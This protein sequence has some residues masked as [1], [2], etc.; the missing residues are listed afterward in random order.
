LIA[1]NKAAYILPDI[2]AP[3]MNIYIELFAQT[4]SMG[5]FG[6]DGAV[7]DSSLYLTVAN[8]AD[9]GKIQFSPVYVSWNGRLITAQLFI[10]PNLKP[11]AWQWSQGINIPIRLMQNG[12]AV[13]TFDFYVVKPCPL[14]DIRSNSER[15]L[16]DG[17]LGMRSPRGAMIVDSLILADGATYT[18]SKQDP[19]GDA[20]NGNQAYLPFTLIALGNITG[21][22]T[23]ISV[24]A[25]DQDGGIG[26]GGGGGAFCDA[27]YEA[28]S[29]MNVGNERLRGGNG[30]T[31]GGI[32]GLHFTG[33]LSSDGA[34]SNK[35]GGIGS[36][37]TDKSSPQ[38]GNAGSSLNGVKGATKRGYESAGGGTGHPFGHSGEGSWADQRDGSYGGGSGEGQDQRGG[39][40]MYADEASQNYRGNG[41]PHGNS[42]IVPLAGGSGGASGNPQHSLQ[43]PS[44]RGGGGGGAI[45]I[46]A[47][48]ITLKAITAN[49][50]N[51]ELGEHVSPSDNCKGGFGSGG[52]IILNSKNN[53]TIDTICAYNGAKDLGQE[54]FGCSGFARTSGK[55]ITKTQM[56][57][58]RINTC[59]MMDTVNIAYRTDDFTIT[60]TTSEAV[61]D[62]YLFF[63]TESGEWQILDTIKGDWAYTF[64]VTFWEQMV[65][66]ICFLYVAKENPTPSSDQYK[67][68]PQYVLSQGAGKIIHLL[69][70][71]PWIELVKSYAID[72]IVACGDTTLNVK[73]QDVWNRG[74]SPLIFGESKYSSSL[75]AQ[76]FELNVKINDTTLEPGDT[77]SIWLA[78][79]IPSSAKTGTYKDTIQ[80][81]HN[82]SLRPNPWIIYVT[83]DLERLAL[84]VHP[85]TLSLGTIYQTAPEQSTNIYVVNNNAIPISFSSITA[86]STQ[87]TYSFNPTSGTVPPNDSI[88]VQ[89]RYTPIA[90]SD[91]GEVSD[92]INVQ[93]DC[94]ITDCFV[95]AY[96]TESPVETQEFPTYLGRF[97]ICMDTIQVQQWGNYVNN[98]TLTFYDMKFFGPDTSIFKCAL[99]KS[100]PFTLYPSDVLTLEISVNTNGV[101]YG[102]K[103]VYLV[104]YGRDQRGAITAFQY[105]ITM[106]VV[107]PFV[108]N[109]TPLYLDTVTIDESGSD[110]TLELTYQ[111]TV[112]GKVSEAFFKNENSMFSV[113]GD[114]VDKTYNY[115]GQ[116]Q[117]VT[118]RYDATMVGDHWDTLVI[119]YA[120]EHCNDT[121]N[122]PVF[123]NVKP[124][125]D[126]QPVI[127]NSI[128][129]RCTEFDNIYDIV[130]EP[131]G[132]DYTVSAA[133]ITHL[134][135]Y[136]TEHIVSIDYEDIPPFTVKDGQKTTIS[137]RLTTDKETSFGLHKIKAE[138]SVV[139]SRGVTKVY[140]FEIDVRVDEALSHTP[141]IN[142]GTV[143]ATDSTAATAT[144]TNLSAPNL[145]IVA[146]KLLNGTNFEVSDNFD[147]MLMYDSIVEATIRV[148]TDTFGLLTDTLMV[149]VQY[150]LCIDTLLIPISADV[151]EKASANIT[152]IAPEMVV[153]PRLNYVLPLKLVADDSLELHSV[154][155]DSLVIAYDNS[156][157]LTQS[158]TIGEMNKDVFGVREVIVL[159]NIRLAPETT[160]IRWL[161]PGD[162]I[163][164]TELAG[165]ALLGEYDSTEFTVLSCKM[166]SLSTTMGIGTIT[167]DNGYLKTIICE[168]G[169]NRLLDVAQQDINAEIVNPVVDVLEVEL[170]PLELGDYTLQVVDIIGREVLK[171]DFNV[172]SRNP[173]QLHLPINNISSGTYI[174][175]IASKSQRFSTRVVK[176]N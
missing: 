17:T 95:S 77:T 118:I 6:T 41:K 136:E 130:L 23:T 1:Q 112:A 74:E 165:A 52:A 64:P 5:A 87:L 75:A 143:S 98:D 60:G 89:V 99:G 142:Y 133:S 71:K 46:T 120:S 96:L 152:I 141:S 171:Y 174:V 162:T 11:N 169:G 16:G 92:R 114:L 79:N 22:G 115:F 170:T 65:D 81:Q 147:N 36:G 159:T 97:P 13:N 121:M 163:T 59:D 68:I 110:K 166:S 146:S 73:I 105:T 137:V 7:S 140:Q 82:D 139:E 164:F 156:M 107:Q 42:F 123:I 101:G 122:V 39:N 28:T 19:D 10:H 116:K 53:Y 119:V 29:P 148:A 66:S 56:P 20:S 113:G 69:D 4:D 8:A 157:F 88:L 158:A 61:G 45:S 153:D 80:I 32:G 90:N 131:I 26:G 48:N 62:S 168:E 67:A 128:M 55:A 138:L 49:G 78:Y 83:F 150:P 93:T 76:G 85:Q 86:T 154:V 38:D 51:G 15:V 50:A 124:R 34:W 108:I 111:P 57:A 151:L 37:G 47:N 100:I 3:G 72:K 24:N 134:A 104:L 18:I 14:G 91:T 27:Y 125:T 40:A 21:I 84:E 145:E 126:I 30:F 175:M 132:Y 54:L 167:L 155:I 33:I 63:K 106:D 31:G 161:L 9:H 135:P 173:I 149:E 58:C 2:G 94:G 43:G 160:D 102:T 12:N 172:T 176:A 127:I 44:G 103:I 35:G 70:G 117:N 109:P 25:K 144:I 129:V